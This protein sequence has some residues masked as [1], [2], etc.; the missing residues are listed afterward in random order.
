M[1]YKLPRIFE[2][3]SQR[4]VTHPSRLH[5]IMTHSHSTSTHSHLTYPTTL[6]FDDFIPRSIPLSAFDDIIPRSI[7]LS[8]FD[9]GTSIVVG[10]LAQTAYTV[11]SLAR[12]AIIP[13]TDTQP[14]VDSQLQLTASSS[15]CKP[16]PTV[17]S[18]PP[19][20]TKSSP[21]QPTRMSQK[22]SSANPYS[23]EAFNDIATKYAAVQ[24]QLVDLQATRTS[25]EQATRIDEESERN[26]KAAYEAAGILHPPRNPAAATKLP[27]LQHCTH[28]SDEYRIDH[29]SIG[30]LRPTDSNNESFEVLDDE[31]YVR[32]VACL[33]HFRT[34]LQ[35]RQDFNYKFQVL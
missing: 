20:S 8:A 27:T 7:P 25:E 24:Q 15:H 6:F 11:G 18:I 32:P 5:S 4:T 22:A 19:T 23:R 3:D 13:Q 31:V 30:Y 10:A 17:S 33:A 1:I 29:K 26:R 34:K 2:P 14:T 35:L 9:E 28:H 21:T 16:Q 12:T